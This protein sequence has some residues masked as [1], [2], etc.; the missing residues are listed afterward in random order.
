[1]NNREAKCVVLGASGFVGGALVERLRREGAQVLPVI[2]RIGPGAAFLAR[3]EL[4]QKVADVRDARGLEEVFQGADVVFHCV[5]GDRATIVD[6]LAKSLEAA[7]RAGVRRFVY[8]SSAIVYGFQPK[9]PI[10]ETSAFDPPGSTSASSEYAKNKA[11]ADKII[12][13]WHG[14]PETVVLRPSIIFGPRSKSWSEGPAREIVAGTAY[15][16]DQGRG[17]MNDIHIEHLLDAMLL[18]AEH[19][20]AAN[21]VYVL[22]DGF[23][24]TWGDYY[25]S[26]CEILGKDFGRLREFSFRE[27]LRETSGLHQF[28]KWAK[29]APVVLSAAIRNE[30]LKPWIKRAPGFEAVRRMAPMRANL[31]ATNGVGVNGA[32]V[33]NASTPSVDMAWLQTFPQT[34]DDRKIRSEL[35]FSARLSYG[36]VMD[37]LRR[38]FRFVGL[39]R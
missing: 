12:S 13:R 38:W 4:Q 5:T 11:A 33:A 7:K 16:V 22:Q 6:G 37:G 9:A 30:P 21:K 36:E 28:G 24:L 23:G 39:V 14:G 26:L 19:P 32:S 2:H 31:N 25:R 27:I 20:A 18:A 29:E 17:Q 15:L 34:I 10:T 35:G 1:M 3:F 8:L